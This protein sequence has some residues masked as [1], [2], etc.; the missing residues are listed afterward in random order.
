MKP[1]IDEALRYLGAGS[2]APEELRRTAEEVAGELAAALQP[3][4]TFQVFSLLR[5]GEGF[6]LANTD[7]ALTGNTARRML[8]QC[9]KAVLLACTLGARFDA[10][11]RTAQVR[12]M[13]RAVILDACGSA[14][15]ESGCDAAE[16]EIRA[17]FPDRY[18]TDRFSPGYGDLPLAL[19]KS[20]CAVLD[21][22]RRLGV[23]VAES[24][25]MN[26]CKSVTAV[27][28]LSDRPQM[29]RIRGCAYC[30]MR[31]RCTLRKGGTT[32]AF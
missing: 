26:P 19:Q 29:A 6:T 7:V 8:A 30:S 21:T 11:L 23:H 27:I 1:N 10:M 3:R 17:R 31:E 13:S 15:V 2:G 14:L 16:E 28:G 9:G 5:E 32:C 20:I 18:L 24:F 22:R 4:Y 25:L 12:D